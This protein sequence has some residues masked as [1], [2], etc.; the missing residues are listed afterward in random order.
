[1]KLIIFSLTLFIF[2]YSETNGQSLISKGP[3][4]NSPIQI[5]S[6]DSYIIP[7]V[8]DKSNVNDYSQDF[9]NYG[10]LVITDIIIYNSKTNTKKNL[11]SKQRSFVYPIIGGFELGVTTIYPPLSGLSNSYKT[12]L[13]LPDKLL[14]VTVTADLNKNGLIS[15]E[16]GISIYI[17]EK[18]GDSLRQI[19]PPNMNLSGLTLS[20]DFKTLFVLL[21][22]DS[23]NDKSFKNEQE[24]LYQVNLNEE[25]SK[26]TLLKIVL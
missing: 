11:F 25:I 6:S 18:N 9:R 24:T 22:N 2:S 17:S 23:N 1:M 10:A 12:S 8:V 19:T 20:K 3:T 21:Q 13:I 16:D 4:Y 5:D 14:F 15:E 26:I 7:K